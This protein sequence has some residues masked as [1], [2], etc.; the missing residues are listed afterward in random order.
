M[1][2][3]FCLTFANDL[4]GKQRAFFCHRNEKA[5]KSVFIL[6]T[7]AL[8]EHTSA[9]TIYLYVHLILESCCYQEGIEPGMLL[10]QQSLQI[11]GHKAN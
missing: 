4:K 2:K 9:L 11:I 8:S 5:I 7:V 6:N 3:Q 10:N 1:L